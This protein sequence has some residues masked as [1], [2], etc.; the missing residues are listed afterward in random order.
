MQGGRFTVSLL[1]F[2]EWWPFS[3]RR[4]RYAVAVVLLLAGG[5]MAVGIGLDLFSPVPGPGMVARQA[6]EPPPRHYRTPMVIG[7]LGFVILIVSGR[8]KA[9]ALG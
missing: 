3:D 7:G 4:I 2:W 8:S 5:L 9:E 6:H 1:Y